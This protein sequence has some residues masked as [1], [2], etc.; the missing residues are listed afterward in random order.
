M[1]SRMIHRMQV[2]PNAHADKASI[3]V[4][5]QS[6][7]KHTVKIRTLKV[8]EVIEMT[9]FDKAWDVVKYE[10]NH[11]YGNNF[12]EKFNRKLDSLKEGARGVPDKFGDMRSTTSRPIRS[13]A[14]PSSMPSPSN[15]PPKTMAYHRMMDRLRQHPLEDR[16]KMVERLKEEEKTQGQQSLIDRTRRTSAMPPAPMDDEKY[17]EV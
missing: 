6:V 7:K 11:I 13:F 1:M 8:I 2:H 10:T 14:D 15:R 12:G 5:I 9:T 4:I 17:E 16:Q 3:H